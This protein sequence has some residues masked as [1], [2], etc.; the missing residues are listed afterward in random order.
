MAANTEP[1]FEITSLVKGVQFVN[2]D[3]TT[4]KAIIAGTD[5]PPEGC[6]V[7]MISIASNDTAA[8]NLAFYIYDGTTA[9]YIGNVVVAIGS[10]YTSISRVDAMSVL[11]P[12]LGYLFIPDG[13]ELRCGP[14]AAVTAAKVVDIVAFGGTYA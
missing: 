4:P 14:V 6:R 12:T 8:V 9:F 13:Y 7:D 3:G 5:I 2:A 1:I 10:G 11:A